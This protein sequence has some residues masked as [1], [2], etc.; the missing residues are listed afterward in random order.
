MTFPLISKLGSDKE[1][2]HSI[3]FIY[4]RY[5]ALFTFPIGFG[6]ALISDFFVE[7]FLSQSWLPVIFPMALVSIA[8]AISS[9]GYVPGVIYK[10]INRPEIL[11]W[12]SMI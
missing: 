11:N 2:L 3:Y 4:V 8:L 5:I 9:V 1:N 12:L 6:L 10:A 7:S